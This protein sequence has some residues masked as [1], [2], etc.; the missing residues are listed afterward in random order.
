MLIGYMRVSKA[1]GSQS[2]HLQR[3]ALIAAGV[4]PAH[5]YEDL[6]SGRRDDRPGLAACLKALREGDTLARLGG[7][8][9]VVML[10][11]L[12]EDAGAV[13]VQAEVI[14]EKIRRVLAKSYTMLGDGEYFHS[15]SFGISLFCGHDKTTEEILK[16]ADIALYKSKEAGRNTIRFFDNAMQTALDL[17]AGLEAGLRQAL[18]RQEFVLYVQPQVDVARQLIGAEALMRWESPQLGFLPPNDFI[19]LA[20]DNALIR[21]VLC[22]W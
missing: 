16:Q 20:E 3:D 6:A 8:E 19:S 22:R 1:D 12:G 13:G 14:A 15:A 2:T 17:R 18:S 10:E 21:L 5:L 4:S 9:F 7:D 11:D